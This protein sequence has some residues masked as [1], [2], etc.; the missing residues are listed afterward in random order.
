[1]RWLLALIALPQADLHLT[2]QSLSGPTAHTSLYYDWRYHPGDDPAWASPE[3]DDSSWQ[4]S[5][6]GLELEQSLPRD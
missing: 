4:R 3:L 5:N 2:P 1:M 6:P